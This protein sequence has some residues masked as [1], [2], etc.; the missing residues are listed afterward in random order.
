MVLINNDMYEE[1]LKILR[2]ET[3]LAPVFS[4]LKDWLKGRFGV[5]ACNFA[6]GESKGFFN[7]ERRFRLDIV[8]F[9][10][11]D[12]HSMFDGMRYD[13]EKRAEIS[14][15]F[16]ELA[17]KFGLENKEKAGDADVNYYDLSMEINTQVESFTYWAIANP[18][19]NQYKEHGVWDIIPTARGIVVFYNKDEDKGKNSR[20]G[21]SDRIRNDYLAELRKRDEF[22]TINEDAFDIRFE[23]RETLDKALRAE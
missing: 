13:D 2:G 7:P 11:K 5:T 17:Q 3:K 20:N 16:H 6:F 12:Y 18:L 4:E 23:S 19:K 14:Q 22:G 15:K 10:K 1:T 21:I 8:L 9:S